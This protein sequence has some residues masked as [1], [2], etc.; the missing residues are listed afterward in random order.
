MTSLHTFAKERC[1][2][3]S[4]GDALLVAEA[5]TWIFPGLLMGRHLYT[6]LGFA[7]SGPSGGSMAVWFQSVF[8]VNAVFSVLQSAAMGG[9]GVGVVDGLV[10]AVAAFGAGG[11]LL[12]RFWGGAQAQGAV[13]GTIG[14]R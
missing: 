14:G 4:L 11:N 2:G 3:V 9:Y 7:R 1:S 8:G 13:N 12:L 6:V 10:R 5:V